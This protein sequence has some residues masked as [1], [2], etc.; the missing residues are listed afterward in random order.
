M[1]K[2]LICDKC[3]YKATSTTSLDKH[4]ESVHEANKI[5]QEMRKR[6]ICDKCDYKTTSTTSLINHK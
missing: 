2:Q 3:D 1:K 6:F 4:K 5:S